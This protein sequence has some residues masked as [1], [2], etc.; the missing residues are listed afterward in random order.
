MRY[1]LLRRSPNEET[2]RDAFSVNVE[3]IP[4][5]VTA[6]VYLHEI[7]TQ[8]PKSYGLL[9]CWTWDPSQDACA[10]ACF[11]KQQKTR[12]NTPREY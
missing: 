10:P 1:K 3:L 12:Y 4:R 11:V 9:S 2:H 8:G 7:P 5:E 6:K